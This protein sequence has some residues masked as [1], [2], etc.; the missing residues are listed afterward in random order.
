VWKGRYSQRIFTLLAVGLALF[1][2]VYFFGPH[3]KTYYRQL[4][5][6][7]MACGDIDDAII[8]ADNLPPGT[9]IHL[10]SAIPCDTDALAAWLNFAGTNL[11]IDYVRPADVTPAY[12]RTLSAIHP[13]AFLVKSA[14]SDALDIVDN[15]MELSPPRLSDGHVPPNMEFALYDANWRSD[16]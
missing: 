14:D 12:M 9:R 3:M 10:I 2:T 5:G 4:Q 13:H 6:Q 15:F 1:Q 16:P 11:I 8:R 7:I